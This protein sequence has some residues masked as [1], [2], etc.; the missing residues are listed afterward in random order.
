MS[1]NSFQNSNSLKPP[2]GPHSPYPDGNPPNRHSDHPVFIF[3]YTTLPPAGFEYIHPLIHDLIGWTPFELYDNPANVKGLISP[4]DREIITGLTAGLINHPIQLDHLVHK[5]GADVRIDLQIR[6]ILNAL[7][8]VMAIEGYAAMEIKVQDNLQTGLPAITIEQMESMNN[9]LGPDFSATETLPRLILAMENAVDYDLCQIMVKEE[10]SELL[11]AL[12]RTHSEPGPAKLNLSAIM[13]SSRA[14]R[15]FL[16]KHVPHT[17]HQN[18]GKTQIAGLPFAREIMI[19][20]LNCLGEVWGAFSLM[21]WDGPAFSPAELTTARYYLS[22]ANLA[23]EK[24]HLVAQV[25]IHERL[26]DRLSPIAVSVERPAKVAEVTQMIGQGALSVSGADRVAVYGHDSE[27]NITHLWSQGLSADGIGK[28]LSL[29]LGIDIRP[30][31]MTEKLNM[32]PDVKDLPVDSQLRQMAESEGIRA[33]ANCPVI[34]ENS[35]QAT[36]DYFYNLP[37]SWTNSEEEALIVYAHQ[38]AIV[39]ENTRLNEELEEV[40]LETV[41]TLAKAL[42]VRDSYTANHSWRLAA[43]A[44][45]TARRLGCDPDQIQLIRWAALLHDVGKIGVPDSI[46]HKAGPLNDE[47]W[48]VMKRHPELGADIVSPMKKLTNVTRI[49]RAHQERFDGTGY[50]DGL[51]GDQIPLAARILTVVDAYGAMTDDRIFRPARSQAEA[52]AEL[53]RCS[54][55]QFDQ[56]VVDVFFQVINANAIAN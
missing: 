3:R 50:P 53:K 15:I 23:I 16:E 52:V 39:L 20:P 5:N 41:L 19:Y 48:L 40:Y 24:M 9:W 45:S 37:H 7:N 17:I 8:D 47:E 32:T 36:I 31:K 6:P 13:N 1:I 25:K 35:Q 43:W 44:E 55:K 11:I 42:D 12:N 26:I 2:V 33:L 27:Q 34:L 14:L 30:G 22:L 21:R 4:Q 38:A 18:E 28:L 46:L 49:I 56:Q 54:G 51:A 29:A 10:K